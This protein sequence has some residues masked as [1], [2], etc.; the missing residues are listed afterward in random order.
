M[1]LVWLS[2]HFQSLPTS[3][4]YSFRCWFTGGWACA[5]SRTPWSP[6][7]DSPVRLGGSPAG[8]TP[9]GFYSQR[10][11]GFSFPSWHPGLCSLSHS[12]VVPPSLSAWVC[13][14]YKPASCCLDGPGALATAMSGILPTSTAHLCLLPVQMKV[15][16]LT[17]WL[18][19]FHTVWFFWKF[20]F[21]LFVLF[22]YWLLSFFWLCEEVKHYLVCICLG[23]KL[24]FF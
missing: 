20:W 1:L 10:F 16:S 19:D 17:P 15:S 14:I 13:G 18:S 8:P 11:W 9:T 6:L 24:S 22:L 7:M 21:C 12:T 23:Q 3:R 2:L 5:Y 4:L